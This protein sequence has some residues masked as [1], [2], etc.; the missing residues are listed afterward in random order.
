MDRWRNGGGILPVWFVCAGCGG[1]DGDGRW[2]R[3]WR[4]VNGRCFE[5]GIGRLGGFEWTQFGRRAE[6]E[7]EE[8][9]VH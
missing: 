3:E 2:M 6:E 4:G 8:K 7:E 9:R 1:E 5:L